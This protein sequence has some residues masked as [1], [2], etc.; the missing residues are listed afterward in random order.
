MS[1]QLDPGL[2]QMGIIDLNKRIR[3]VNL[4]GGL[5]G[6][7]GKGEPADDR[8][9]DVARDAVAHDLRRMKRRFLQR[10]PQHAVGAVSEAVAILQ[11]RAAS[12][13]NSSVGPEFTRP[14]IS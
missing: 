14:M 4:P 2:L 7:Q 9:L 8:V 12:H 1:A 10:L 5:G 11:S 6:G 3:K 13:V